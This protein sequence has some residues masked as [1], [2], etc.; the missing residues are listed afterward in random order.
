MTSFLPNQNLV[1][2]SSFRDNVAR[3]SLNAHVARALEEYL[4]ARFDPEDVLLALQR[5]RDRGPNLGGPT[6]IV[7]Y[8]PRGATY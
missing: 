4:D 6:R 7:T 2:R 1:R 8:T 3:D 5:R